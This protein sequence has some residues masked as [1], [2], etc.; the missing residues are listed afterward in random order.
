MRTRYVLVGLLCLIASQDADSQELQW[1]HVGSEPLGVNI[2]S[3]DSDGH[4]WALGLSR[5]RRLS[6]PYGPSQPW[7]N[8]GNNLNL[9]PVF[10]LGRDT[11]ILESRIE[12]L[13]RSFDNGATVQPS[14]PRFRLLIERVIDVSDIIPG[15]SLILAASNGVDWA[16]YSTDRGASWHT[17]SAPENRTNG[18]EA[19]RLAVV[20]SGPH[21]GRIVGAGF[22]GLA[23]SDDRGV[24]YQRVP[25]WW[26]RARFLSEAVGVLREAAPGGGDRLVATLVD[27]ARPGIISHVVV[28]D[29]GGDTWRETFGI[30]GDPNAAGAEVV[31]LGGG[32]GVI[33]MNGGHVWQTDD[34]GETWRIVGVVPRSLVD[35]D[36]DFSLNPRVTWGFLGPD[37]RLYVGGYRLGGSNPGWTFRTVLPVVAGEAEPEASESLGVSVRPN[38]AGGRVEVVLRVAEAGAA[39]VVVVDALGREVVVVLDGAVPAGE[40]VRA[41]ETGGW[42]VGVYVVR[43]LVGSQSASTRLVVAR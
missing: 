28:S 16:G 6:P 2:P 39:R 24:S 43:A 29:D 1:E 4:M 42:P 11:L 31:D 30:T 10:S 19:R 17:S 35:P 3:I 32:R 5:I 21:A 33:L 26:Q 7:Q 14:D 25:G 18:D 13:G 27:S 15:S 34:A 20:R 9:A 22:W 41:L 8:L 12:G 40:T 37:G 36:V 23:T 38:P